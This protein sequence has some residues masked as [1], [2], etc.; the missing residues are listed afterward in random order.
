MNR[1]LKILVSDGDQKH[2]LGI[3]RALGGLGHDVG[4][5]SEN[6]KCLC[7]YSKYTLREHVLPNYRD[8]SFP[9]LLIA[10][11]NDFDYDVFFPVGSGAF[12]FAVTNC[13][14]LR[15]SARADFLIPDFPAFNIAMSKELTYFFAREHGVLC[16]KTFLPESLN[17][18]KNFKGEI[19]FPVVIKAIEL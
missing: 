11:L 7:S 19:T 8:A 6:L 2:T 5:F 18:V 14:A 1:K 16:P 13:Q 4:V 15:Q 10:V 9:Q 12:E 3:V 17:D